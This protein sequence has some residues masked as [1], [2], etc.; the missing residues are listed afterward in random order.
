MAVKWLSFG[1]NHGNLLS[2][3]EEGI[4]IN[5]SSSV[6]HSFAS[7]PATEPKIASSMFCMAVSQLRCVF[8]MVVF[9]FIEM[10]KLV[11][12]DCLFVLLM[13]AT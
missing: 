1:L 8:K 2:R 3:E 5:V 4:C 9:S 6:T 13:L 10:I 7:L 11:C 12:E